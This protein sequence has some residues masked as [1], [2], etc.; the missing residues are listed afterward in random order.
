VQRRRFVRLADAHA[1]A[2]LQPLRLGLGIEAAREHRAVV[3]KGFGLRRAAQKGFEGLVHL[4]FLGL[5]GRWTRFRRGHPRS[6][7]GR[8]GRLGARLVPQAQQQALCHLHAVA[9]A[10][11]HVRQRREVAAQRRHRRAHVRFGEGLAQQRRLGGLGPLDDRGHAAE[12][13]AQRAHRVA[14]ELDREGR[15]DGRDVAVVALGDLVAAQ[16]RASRRQ[17]HAQRTHEF[18]A[19]HPVLHVVDVEVLERQRALLAAVLQHDLRA[20]RDQHGRAIADRRAVG[21]VAAHRAGVPDRRRGKAHPDLRQRGHARRECRPGVLERG[22][23]ADDDLVGLLL[24]APQ[25]VD[26]ADGD[27][28]AQVAETL[29]CPQADVGRAGKQARLRL[30]R[31]QRREGLERARR[32]EAAQFADG[33]VQRGVG[34]RRIGR[35]ALQRLHDRCGGKALR[36]QLEHALAGVEDGAIAGAAA[37][38]ARQLVGE[39]LPRRLRAGLA[40]ALVGARHRHRD[41]RRAEAALRAVAL[42]QR[43]LHRMQLAPGDRAQVLHRQQRLAVERGQEAQAGVDG[44]Q[45]QATDDGGAGAGRAG[46]FGAIRELGDDDGAGAAVALV[47]ALLGA[48]GARVLAQPAQHGGRRRHSGDLD[49]RTAVEEADRAQRALDAGSVGSGRGSRR[50]GRR[51]GR[52]GGRDRHLGRLGAGKSFRNTVSLM[53]MTPRTR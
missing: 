4:A 32:V 28:V 44:A 50:G 42:D 45:A 5:R 16:L 48:H 12:G 37:E 52:R 26:L 34:Q 23:G 40:V 25:R 43:L 17:R 53:S 24:D 49:H 15:A 41:A 20:E 14:V 29:V 39:L 3:G 33:R 30:A 9:G 19:L 10:G 51:S 8:Q 31:A 36:R 11:T 22:A 47:A 13:Q 7:R 38:V 18:A 6:L 27:Q 21:D 46:R 2:V 35:Q 1:R